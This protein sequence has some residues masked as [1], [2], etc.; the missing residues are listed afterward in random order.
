MYCQERKKK[1]KN[2]LYHELLLGWQ[3]GHE[4]LRYGR[5]S[6]LSASTG[7]S[8]RT[9]RRWKSEIEEEIDNAGRKP[10]DSEKDI[11]KEDQSSQNA[12][13]VENDEN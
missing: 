8:K 2:T 10:L 3:N 12:E 1:V 6:A 4:G 7:I 13:E 9:L 5:I 11:K